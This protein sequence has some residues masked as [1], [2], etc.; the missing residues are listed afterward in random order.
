[1]ADVGSL[2]AC[3]AETG[4]SQKRVRILVSG[5]VQGVGFRWYCR[6]EAVRRG[7]GGSVRNLDDGRVEAAFEGD[8]EAVEAMVEWCRQGPGW[9]RVE[10]VE[11]E[12]E[13]PRGEAQFRITR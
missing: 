1:M 8:P 10:R 5:D 4:Q 6:E 13:P 12:E 11:L 7:V 9:A 2:S 3:M